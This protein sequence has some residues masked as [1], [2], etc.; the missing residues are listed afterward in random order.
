[1]EAHLDELDFDTSRADAAL[2][3]AGI[4]IKRLEY[5][6]REALERFV[7][8]RFPNWLP[9]VAAVKP[10]E[11]QRV[12]IARRK[13]SVIGF[14][15]SHGEG[16][17]P[18]GVDPRYRFQGIGRILLLRCLRDIR[19]RGHRVAF[20]GWANFPFY[21]KSINAPITRVMWQMEKKLRE[22]A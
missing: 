21:A 19:E 16:F 15:V 2:R 3:R 4:E 12:H 13:R 17:G 18:I 5:R 11:P 1:M 9:T 10:D 20:I 8:R 6:E 22:E 7:S 14:A